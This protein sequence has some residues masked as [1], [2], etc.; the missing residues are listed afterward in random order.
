LALVDFLPSLQA[1]SAI[2]QIIHEYFGLLIYS[3]ISQ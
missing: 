3:I 2:A 1:F